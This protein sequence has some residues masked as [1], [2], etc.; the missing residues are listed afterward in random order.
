MSKSTE[1]HLKMKAKNEAKRIV[2][3]T[4]VRAFHPFDQDKYSDLLK[5]LIEEAIIKVGNEMEA[6]FEE[7]LLDDAKTP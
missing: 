5:E 2:E 6:K 7:Y 1:I 3:K 4:F